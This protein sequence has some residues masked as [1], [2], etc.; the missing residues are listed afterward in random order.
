M[1]LEEGNKMK[2]DVRRTAWNNA[3]DKALLNNMQ[4]KVASLEDGFTLLMKL[5]GVNDIDELVETFIKKQD[6]NM[7]EFDHVNKLGLQ[8]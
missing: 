4:Q 1:S 3:K 5:S 2:K 7:V 8:V 6:K